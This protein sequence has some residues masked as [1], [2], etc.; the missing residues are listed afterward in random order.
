MELVAEETSIYTQS[1]AKK[2]KNDYNIREDDQIDASNEAANIC[3]LTGGQKE[4]IK[5]EDLDLSEGQDCYTP[6]PQ[7]PLFSESEEYGSTPSLPRIIHS[8]MRSHRMMPSE[9]D[10]KI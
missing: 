6:Q 9:R 10:M 4:E 2:D 7:R 5:Q 3:L 8:E 1:T